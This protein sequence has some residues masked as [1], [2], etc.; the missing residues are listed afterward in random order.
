[1]HKRSLY[2][3]VNLKLRFK[4]DPCILFAKS[5]IPSLEYQGTSRWPSIAKVGEKQKA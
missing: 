4:W 3:H 5:C 1:M 2:I